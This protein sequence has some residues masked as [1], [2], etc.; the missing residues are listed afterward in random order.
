VQPFL[1]VQA[2]LTELLESLL[3][4]GRG[5]RGASGVDCAKAGSSSPALAAWSMG[6]SGPYPTPPVIGISLFLLRIL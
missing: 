3:V 6:V 2:F 5:D 4:S 1:A